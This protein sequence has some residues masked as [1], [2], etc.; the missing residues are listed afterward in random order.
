MDPGSKKVDDRK[1]EWQTKRY[2]EG[3][4]LDA[5]NFSPDFRLLAIKLQRRDWPIKSTLTSTLTCPSLNSHIVD[6]PEPQV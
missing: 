4:S 3:T 2:F 5:R 6:F 1:I